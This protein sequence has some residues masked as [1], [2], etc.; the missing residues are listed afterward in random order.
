MHGSQPRGDFGVDK[1][2]MIS[3]FCQRGF[4]DV[5]LLAA[6]FVVGVVSTLEIAPEDPSFNN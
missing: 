5:C 4:G 2:S 3:I 1:K 6:R